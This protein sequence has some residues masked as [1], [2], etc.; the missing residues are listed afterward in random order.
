MKM[1]LFKIRKTINL[2]LTNVLTVLFTCLGYINIVFY[3]NCQLT[4]HYKMKAI[5]VIQ[6]L[7]MK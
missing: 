7:T 3:K 1:M 6:F 4:I 5:S 2:T